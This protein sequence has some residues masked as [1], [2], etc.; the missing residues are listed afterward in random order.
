MRI[1]IT[2]GPTREYFD[3]VRF[4]SNAST[5]KMGYAI[6]SQA[7]SRGHDVTLISGPVALQPPASVKTVQVTSAEDMFTAAERAFA[8]C[9]A[10]IMT[11]A[12]CDY[13]PAEQRTRKFK[14]TDQSLQIELT[15]TRD[16]CAH[17]GGIKGPRLVIGFAL[18]DHDAR[19]HAADKLARKRCDAIVLNSP[20]TLGSEQAAIEVLTA[21]GHWHEKQVGTKQ[22]LAGYL[23]GLV[24]QLGL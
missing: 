12:V 3:T 19:A 5:G 22:Q 1:L 8:D 4:I 23:V 16:I 9:D 14:K 6:A 11:A 7:V 24:E 10:A 17:L 20:Q 15:P 13:R 2:A 18:E 21:D